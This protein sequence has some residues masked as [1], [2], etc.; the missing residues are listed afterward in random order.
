MFRALAL[1]PET[2][3][4]LL[5]L[6]LDEMDCSGMRLHL[7]KVFRFKSA[8]MLGK[9]SKGLSD[10]EEIEPIEGRYKL[11][12]G[13]YKIRYREVVKVPNNC[14]A[15]AI[16]RSSLLRMGV[17]IFSAVW[18]PGYE[19]RGEGMMLVANPFGVELEVGA[20]IAQLVFISMDRATSK[21][22][23]GSYFRENI[24]AKP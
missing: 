20:Q 1:A 17:V 2:L 6:S 4:K 18:D 24:G 10:V 11:G 9:S 15:I 8:G 16:P 3:S 22:Y 23:R 5:G 13:C 14:I 12:C 7:D 19:G 21:V